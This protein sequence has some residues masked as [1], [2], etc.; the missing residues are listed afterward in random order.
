MGKNAGLPWD[1]ILSAELCRHFKP[2]PEV[3]QMAAELLGPEPEAVM[4]VAA[5]NGDLLA[6]RQEGLRTAFVARPTEYGPHQSRD[7]K[8]EH[9]W[10]LVAKDFGELAEKLGA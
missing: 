4:L 1:V 10:D 5:H 2:D 9:E 6:A 7:F 8:A 3:Y